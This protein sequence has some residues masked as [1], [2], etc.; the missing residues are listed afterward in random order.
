VILSQMRRQAQLAIDSAEVIV[1][2][3][4]LK[5]GVT[6][7]DRE[8]ASMLQKSS[9]PIVL[10]VNKCDRVG[11]LPPIFTNLQPWPGGPDSRFLG[12]RVRHGGPA[13]RH[14]RSDRFLL[15]ESVE[16]DYVPVAVV[17]KPNVGKSSLINYIVGEERVIVSD[18]AGTTR[19]ATT[20]RLRTN[21]A[22]IFLSIPRASEGRAK[23]ARRSS[24]TRCFGH[25][26]PWTG[27][28]SAL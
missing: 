23:S 3:V 2:V 9:K 27:P 5:S 15:F 21:S 13:R 28:R 17:G 4:D 8:V 10:C 1:L 25:I 22:I 19:D 20:R 7:T 18:V 11:D 12:P 24:T 26:W 14:M 16:S 6:A